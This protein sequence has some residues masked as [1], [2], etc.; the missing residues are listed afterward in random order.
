MWT[1]KITMLDWLTDP[2]CVYSVVVHTRRPFNREFIEIALAIK[3]LFA[4]LIARMDM[5]RTSCQ[6]EASTPNYNASMD[7]LK[8]SESLI[9]YCDEGSV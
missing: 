7:M 5:V 4:V 3:L 8:M 6:A 9:W 2:P 1:L